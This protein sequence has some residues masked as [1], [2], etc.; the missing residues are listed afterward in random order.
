MSARPPLVLFCGS[1][2]WSDRERIRADLQSLPEGSVVIEGGAR[3][4]DRIARTEAQ[5]LGL[6][7][8]TVNALWDHYGRSAGYRRNEAMLRLE[9]DFLYA[10]P[11][12]GPGTA[13]MIRLAE[14]EC[15]PVREP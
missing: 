6:H 3:G 10:Y 13:Q 14:A 11:L 8:A 7:V 15:I 12:G 2:E 1:R 9:P 5:R 4:A